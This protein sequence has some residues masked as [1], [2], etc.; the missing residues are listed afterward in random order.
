MNQS[1]HRCPVSPRRGRLDQ[2]GFDH[3][4]RDRVLI[5]ALL[6]VLPMLLAGCQSTRRQALHDAHQA[7][8]H[9]GFEKKRE[10]LARRDLQSRQKKARPDLPAEWTEYQIARRV[11]DDQPGLP[12]DAFERARAHKQ[13]MRHFSLRRNAFVG[14]GEKSSPADW[15]WLGPSNIAGRGRTI[16]FDPRDP[17][18]I[19]TAGVSGGVWLSE[20]GGGNWSPL[21]D[22]AENINIGSLLI[23]PVDP[24]TIYAGTGELYRNSERPYAAMWGQGILRSRDGG[25]LFQQ[26]IATAND[27]FRYVSDLA[28][29]PHDHR[30]LY[31]ATNTGLW[32]SDDAGASFTQIL[33]PEA[34]GG[35]PRYEGCTDILMLPDSDHDHLLVS[36]GSRSTSDRYWLPGPVTPAACSNGPCPAALFRNPDAAG[37]GAWSLVLSEAGMGR[38][39]LA[40]APSQ[41]DTVYAV[42]ASL[43]R[44]FDRS[45]D[46]VGDYDNG[47]H[48]LW[49]SVDGGQ[50]WQ[51]RL[52]NNSLDALST[53]LFSYADGMEAPRCGFGS[54]FNYGAGWYNQAIAVDPVNPDT[55]WVAGMDIYRSDDGGAH[56]GRASYWFLNGS[57]PAGV[58]AD[59]HAFVFHPGFDGDAEQRLYVVNDG[60]VW[61]TGQA[62]GAVSRGIQAACGPLAGTL[63]WTPLIDGLGTVQYYAGAA[64]ADNQRLVAGAQDNGSHVLDIGDGA[65]G[66]RHVLGGD[67][68]NVAIDPRDADRL[69]VSYQGVNLH[70]SEDGGQTLT[71]AT[72]GLND[73]SLF[74]MPYQ[75]DPN[76]ADRLWAGGRRVWRS[77]DRGVSWQP[78]SALLGSGFDDLISAVAVQPG[79][80]N[81]VLVANRRGIFRQSQATSAGGASVWPS[82]MPRSGWVS[83]LTFDPAQPDTVYATYSTFGG[84][85][86]WRSEDAGINWQPLDGEGAD[87]LPDIAVH[88]LAVDPDNSQRLFLG[89]DL[90]VFVSVDGG[91]NWAAENNGFASAI[92]EKLQTNPAI[93]ND[94][95]MLY[96]FTYGRGAWRVPLAQLDGRAD[97]RIDEDISGS[98]YDPNNSGHGWLVESLVLD[99]VRW[100]AVTWYAYDNGEPMWLLGIAPA[101]GDTVTVPMTRFSGGDFPPDFNPASVSSEP[102]GELTLWFDSANGG[103]AGWQSSIDGFPSGEAA[104]IRITGIDDSAEADQ[105]SGCHSGSWYDPQQSGH[106]LQLEI[107]DDGQGG[108][109]VVAVWYHYLDGEDAWLLGSG[110]VVGNQATLQANVTRGANFP[111]DFDPAT[112]EHL[113][114]G[115]LQLDLVDANRIELSWGTDRPEYSDGALSLRRLTQLAGHACSTAP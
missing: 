112:V 65:G 26:L 72:D 88:S 7:S 31:A 9:P 32:R 13:A 48:A 69:Y 28:L 30:R 21:S 16:Q 71:R 74:I 25:R 89:T 105:F 99:G 93:G 47:L 87:Q 68:A 8:H 75:L 82:I 102:W 61:V 81:V 6:L 29:S 95:A 113:S 59:Q 36:C 51:A 56:F 58:H 76:A 34:D 18:R 96:A 22:G 90:G 108:R 33:K 63:G 3:A 45:G 78:A 73:A 12:M 85:H 64:S 53:Y 24:D 109:L 38:T 44:G 55:V 50:T 39:S 23:D 15:E 103:R 104:F 40:F 27:D 19:Y 14:V 52:R 97:Y 92:V 11:A 66:W 79:D 43:S 67:G 41:P 91:R 100:L 80:S 2:I 57:D 77:G 94:P 98:F 35:G 86:V 110:P 42:A 60:G 107:V 114:W 49:R 106:G 84:V 54:V 62:R 17:E 101:S 111:P 83:S 1:P 10:K 70:R 115:S 20:D 4:R 5:V 46:G 37:E